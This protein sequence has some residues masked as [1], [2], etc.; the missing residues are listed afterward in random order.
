[1]TLELEEEEK[2][3]KRIKEKEVKKKK[4]KEEPKQ[5]DSTFLPLHLQEKEGIIIIHVFPSGTPYIVTYLRRA[6]LEV[7]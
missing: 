3:K 1:M 2:K 6:Q 4:K 5:A 7:E